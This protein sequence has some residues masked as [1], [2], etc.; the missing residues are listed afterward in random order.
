MDADTLSS[1]IGSECYLIL[2]ELCSFIS[3]TVFQE[4]LFPKNTHG[5]LE[6]GYKYQSMLII[7]F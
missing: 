6:E 5:N 3:H 4:I 1:N 7:N 2:F